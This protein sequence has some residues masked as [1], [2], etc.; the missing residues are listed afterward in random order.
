MKR[1]TRYFLLGV[2]VGSFLATLGGAL[3]SDYRETKSDV[4]ELKHYVGA[5]V[6]A[7]QGGG[8]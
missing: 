5:I 4:Q 7:L 8:R 6:A 3:V 2:L 1:R